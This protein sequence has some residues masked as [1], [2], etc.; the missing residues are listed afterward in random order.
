MSSPLLDFVRRG[1]QP[2]VH[3]GSAEL[4]LGNPTR[5]KGIVKLFENDC[6]AVDVNVLGGGMQWLT[7]F[8]TPLRRLWFRPRPRSGRSSRFAIGVH[9]S[10]HDRAESGLGYGSSLHQ[11]LRP[12]VELNSSFGFEHDLAEHPPAG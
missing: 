3:D 6:G 10:D 11:F 12:S 1:T 7:A 8:F 9:S 5:P 4:L 2:L